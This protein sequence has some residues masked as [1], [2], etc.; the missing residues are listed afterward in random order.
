MSIKCYRKSLVN[1]S[2]GK[3]ANLQHLSQDWG[4]ALSDKEFCDVK[5][6]CGDTTFDCHQLVLG[7]RSP[8][9]R[10]M[11]RADMREKKSRKVNVQD[12]H[13]KVFA[14]LLTFI[15]T[16]KTLNLE[17]YAEEL[18]GAAEKY[19]LNFCKGRSKKQ[20]DPELPVQVNQ[21]RPFL[22]F[23][24]KSKRKEKAPEE[25]PATAKVSY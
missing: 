18:L 21:K 19:Q 14:E 4:N 7:V 23:D 16:G 6:I 11:F 20:I 12:L 13:P 22:P 17:R 25:N 9:F 10:A 2:I 3:M 1:D 8:V 24:P 15:Y 5:I